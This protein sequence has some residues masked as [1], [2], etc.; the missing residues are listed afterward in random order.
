M[1]IT[2]ENL[3]NSLLRI[4]ATLDSKEIGR[5]STKKVKYYNVAHVLSGE[6]FY[7]I[8]LI[9]ENNRRGCR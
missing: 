4:N 2:V 3:K 7:F 6:K 9:K 8:F 1:S 5:I